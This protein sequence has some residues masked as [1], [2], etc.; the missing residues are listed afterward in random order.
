MTRGTFASCDAVSATIRLH[1]IHIATA[2]I[3]V[4]GVVR[5]VRFYRGPS[6]NEI[7]HLSIYTLQGQ[8]GVGRRQDGACA[9]NLIKSSILLSKARCKCYCY[10]GQPQPH[11]CCSCKSLIRSHLEH[12]PQIRQ[13]CW[14]SVPEPVPNIFE[15]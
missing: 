9:V 6:I 8:G 10:C 5:A 3:D 11:P 7:G 13:R 12:E 4:G 2:V 15:Q 14:K 1:C